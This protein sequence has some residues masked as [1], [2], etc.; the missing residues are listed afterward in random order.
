MVSV[1]IGRLIQ[2]LLLILTVKIS[3]TL[4]PPS[5]MGKISI[6]VSTIA[7][8]ALL[9]LN[10]VGMYM[11]RRILIW[12]QRGVAKQYLRV[13]WIYVLATALFSS[14]ILAALTYSHIWNTDINNLWLIGLVAVN[15]VFA[16]VNQVAIPNLNLLGYQFQFLILSIATNLFS[17]IFAVTLV[18]KFSISAELWLVGILLGNIIVG[19]YGAKVF[20]EKLNNSNINNVSSCFTQFNKLHIHGFFNYTWPIAFASLLGWIQSQSYRYSIE[21]NTGLEALG[22][23]VAGYG[24]SAGLIGA[25][26]SIFTTYFQPKFYKRISELDDAFGHSSA[27]SSYAN[28]IFPALLLTTVLIICLAPSLTRLLLGDRYHGVEHFVVLGAIAEMLRLS[29]GIFALMAYAKMKTKLLLIPNFFGAFLAVLLTYLLIS[30]Y[31]V[32]GVAYALILSFLASAYLSFYSIKK[33]LAN[34]F[35]FKGLAFAVVLS[36]GLWSFSKIIRV[37]NWLTFHSS[38]LATD[39]SQSFLIGLLFIYFLYLI[40]KPVLAENKA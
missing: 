23:F 3:T 20:Y 12:N 25:F 27:W 22:L 19:L 18:L 1:F 39:F 17:L 15:I 33:Y 36:S 34:H 2:F 26:D 40:L 14:C 10:P 7:G 13:F 29:S 32:I 16:T 37:N 21:Q 35:P 24:I 31:G 30:K 38:T 9:L 8:F 6:V 5:E 4:L 28:S 11:N